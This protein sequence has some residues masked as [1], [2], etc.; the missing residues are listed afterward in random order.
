MSTHPLSWLLALPSRPLRDPI[1]RHIH[2]PEPLLPL[3]RTPPFQRLTRIRQ[4]GP[5]HLLY[6]GATHTRAS[7]SLGVF[8]LA[9]RM[10]LSLAEHPTFPHLTKE[11]TL[12]FLIASLLHDLGHYPYTHSLKDL[13]LP[14]GTTLTPH[15]HLSARLIQEEPLASL[16][17]AAG[18]DP[19]IPA[20]VIDSTLPTPT[21]HTPFLR[22]LLSGVLDPDKLDYLTRDAFFCGVPY[23]VQDIDHILTTIRPTACGLAITPSGIPSIEH[24]LFSKY[25][26]YRTVYWHRTV[27][28]ATAMVKKT[29]YHALT[30]GVIIPDRF[31]LLDDAGLLQL[32]PR[33]AGPARTLIEDVHRGTLHTCIWEVP[34]DPSSPLHRAIEHL[35]TR[36][37][38][39]THLARTLF[40]NA[41][42]HSIILDL[43]EPLIFETDIHIITEDEHTIPYTE[44]RSVFTPET[45][46]A[47]TTT[48]RTIRLFVPPSLADTRPS[49]RAIEDTL[50][51]AL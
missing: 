28:A 8:A 27:R 11:E 29:I 17:R 22:A 47:F 46:H 7:H 39:D 24:I 43:P 23:G 36:I 21:P 49:P 40:P 2:L 12:G 25:L 45:V 5:T 4:L 13:V 50:M 1:W 37:R 33:S 48:I 10:L 31:Y 41:P 42:D 15:E 51:E 6:P 16:I 14:D 30:E 26:M 3:L 44:A 32:I 9:W 19:L 38:L 18:C 20:A 34:Y 35:P